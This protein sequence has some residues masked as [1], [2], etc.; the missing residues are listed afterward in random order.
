MGGSPL[1][2][3]NIKEKEPEINQAH[4][5]FMVNNSQ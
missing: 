3:L 2:T 4:I 5:L 1:A